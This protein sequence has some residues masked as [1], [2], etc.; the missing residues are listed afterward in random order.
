MKTILSTS[1]LLFASLALHATP[2]ALVTENIAE[3]EATRATVAFQN[4]LSAQLAQAGFEVRTADSRF[5]PVE[6]EAGTGRRLAP[7]DASAIQVGRHLEAEQVLIATIDQ[8]L[9]EQRRY[10]GHGLDQE[11]QFVRIVGSY[12][13]LQMDGSTVDGGSVEVSRSFRQDREI[14]ME[15]NIIQAMLGDLA[16]SMANELA[17]RKDELPEAQDVE[18]PGTTEITIRIL[19]SDFSV[20][21]V[22]ED[23]DGRLRATGERGEIQVD[24]VAVELDGITVGS[25]SGKLSVPTGLQRIRL[26]REGFEDWTRL[27]NVTPEFTLTVRMGMTDEAF[28]RWKETAAFLEGLVNERLLTEAEADRLRKEAEALRSVDIRY[29]VNVWADAEPIRLRHL[30]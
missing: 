21:E 26:T 1:L 28:A 5:E 24:G 7:R 10:R 25:A 20:P 29:D 8:I 3:P 30:E 4:Q 9:Q 27:I 2:L 16:R 22:V 11:N 19:A 12:R 23:E 15:G 14:T 6:Q 13:L 18:V 17:E